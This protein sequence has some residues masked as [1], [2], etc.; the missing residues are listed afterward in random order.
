V[1]F[2]TV[3]FT[4]EDKEMPF[5]KFRFAVL[6][7]I[8]L[9]NTDDNKMPLPLVGVCGIVLNEIVVGRSNAYPLL[10]LKFTML[11]IIMFLMLS[12]DNKIH[13]KN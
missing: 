13:L 4:A 11:S 8:R 6:F 5:S 12:E 1:L 7:F 10:L 9:S 3:L 2:I